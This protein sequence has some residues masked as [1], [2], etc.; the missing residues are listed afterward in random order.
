MNTNKI[1][2]SEFKKICEGISRDREIICKHNPIGTEEETLLWMT[3]GAL[4]SILSL[5]EN[6]TPCFS[7]KPTAE[8]YRDAISFVLKNRQTEDFDEAEYLNEF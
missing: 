5:D 3:L 4:I 8:T 2:E 1:S 6:E 7:G